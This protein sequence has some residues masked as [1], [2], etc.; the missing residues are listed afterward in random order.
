MGDLNYH[1]LTPFITQDNNGGDGD[2]KQCLDEY[3]AG[4]W[5]VSWGYVSC[6]MIFLNGEYKKQ[7]V[8]TFTSISFESSTFQM[9]LQR[10]RMMFRP[11]NDVRPCNNPCR[12]GGTCEYN[13]AT[14]SAKCSCAAEFKGPTC[15]D[16]DNDEA[17]DTDADAGSESGNALPAVVGGVLLLLILIAGAVVF[18]AI[19]RRKKRATDAAAQRELER[20]L[21]EREKEENSGLFSYVGL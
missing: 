18:G 5:Y 13:V 19:L 15:E 21:A 1:K 2:S 17:I 10:S 12:N 4:W 11:Q 16:P 7:A 6:V 8:E 14:K 3:R 9:A 20:E